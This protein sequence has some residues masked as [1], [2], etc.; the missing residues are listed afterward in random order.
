[1]EMPSDLLLLQTVF[2]TV[3]EITP[4]ILDEPFVLIFENTPEVDQKTVSSNDNSDNVFLL[5]Q[6]EELKIKL[7][8]D[9]LAD[10][11]PESF[12]FS[13]LNLKCLD[14]ELGCKH[15]FTS[16]ELG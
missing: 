4:G 2:K 14:K 3:N 9:I 7:V 12:S 6:P 5:I 15:F 8:R 1:M 16:L 13:K 11:D 10:Y